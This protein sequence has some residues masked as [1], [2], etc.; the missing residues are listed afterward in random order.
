MV[1]CGTKTHSTAC[2]NIYIFS[3]GGTTVA[4]LRAS[5]ACRTG[6]SS[7]RLQL[8]ATSPL[9]ASLAGPREPRARHAACCFATCT[10]RYAPAAA[11]ATK[12]IAVSMHPAAISS[13][14]WRSC[15]SAGKRAGCMRAKRRGWPY[16]RS[17]HV[18]CA[19]QPL[20]IPYGCHAWHAAK[21]KA[22]CK[23]KRKMKSGRTSTWTSTI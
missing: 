17:G 5:R 6:H 2:N 4:A 20:T 14:R 9:T 3:M 8:R 22:R 12:G 7:A 15:C 21:E 10:K 11:A 23:R 1:L 18:A 19:L 16:G 13:P